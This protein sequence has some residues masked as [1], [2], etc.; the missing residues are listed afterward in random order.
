MYSVSGVFC[1]AIRFTNSSLRIVSLVSSPTDVIFAQE[2]LSTISAASGSNKRL[3]SEPK[4]GLSIASDSPVPVI[5]PI[6]IS[7]L[8]EDAKFGIQFDR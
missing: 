6:K 5:P 2:A 1:C 8:A 4:S 7:S 3:K